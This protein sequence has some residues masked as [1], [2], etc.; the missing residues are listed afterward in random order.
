MIAPIFGDHRELHA[1]AGAR[2]DAVAAVCLAPHIARIIH[3]FIGSLDGEAMARGIERKIAR[4]VAHADAIIEP[5]KAFALERDLSFGAELS[6]RQLERGSL[7]APPAKALLTS[8]ALIEP[9]AR[10]K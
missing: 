3:R 5:A 4:G 2:L 8:E 1:D 9:D 10:H 6:H 7:G